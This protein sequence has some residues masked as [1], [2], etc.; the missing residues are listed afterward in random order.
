MCIR[1]F[2]EHPMLMIRS[3]FLPDLFYSLCYILYQIIRPIQFNR[4]NV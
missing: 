2:K 3:S 4:E 1:I